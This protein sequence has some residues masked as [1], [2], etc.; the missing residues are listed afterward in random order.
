MLPNF[1]SPSL[2]PNIYL[3]SDFIFAARGRQ[4]S[5]GVNGAEED[6]EMTGSVSTVWNNIENYLPITVIED[7]EEER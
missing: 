5:V 3:P 6:N 1:N 2:V 4:Y 7:I